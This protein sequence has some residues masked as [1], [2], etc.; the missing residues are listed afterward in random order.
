MSLIKSNSVQIGQSATATQ[1]FTLAV[2][3]SPDGTIKLA[4]GNAGATTQDVLSVDASGNVSFNGKNYLG[5]FSVAPTLNNQGLPLQSGNLYWNTVSNNLWAYNGTSWLITNFNETTP[6]FT[7]FATSG[8]ARSLEVRMR[9]DMSSVRDW[10]ATGNGTT[11]D[12]V[13]IQ[14]A[15]DFG[16]IKL[17][18]PVG[19]Y[20]VTAPLTVR[21]QKFI[22]GCGSSSSIVIDHSGTGI[23]L[24]PVGAGTSNV[25]LSGVELQDMTFTRPG[26]ITNPGDNIWIRQCNGFSARGVISRN[27]S[28]CFR[29]SGGQL[30]SLLQCRAFV[31]N[32][33]IVPQAD[34]GLVIF[35]KA[36]LSGGGYQPCYT[37]TI[38]DFVGSA[39][40]VL[41]Y[42]IKV[43]SIDGLNFSNAY[44]A[45]CSTSLIGVIREDINTAATAINLTNLYLDCTGGSSGTPYGI[46]CNH[47]LGAPEYS[48][49]GMNV[50]NCHIANNQDTGTFNSLV[51]FAKRAANVNFSNCYFANGGSPYGVQLY[52]DGIGAR[53]GKY[54]FTGCVFFNLS[55]AT[56]GGAI[57]S[58]DVDVLIVTGNTF[59]NT[60][61]AAYQV[62]CDGDVGSVT[63]IGN[64]A[65]NSAASIVT[66]SGTATVAGDVILLNAGT[67]SAP[68]QIRLALPTSSV[69]L[70]SGAM[71]NDGGTVKI[72]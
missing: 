71:W 52:D 7:Q 43:K 36:S 3:S 1:N 14:N 13:A 50:S 18:F 4:R 27:G 54:V 65:D 56:G 45:Y 24:E 41:Q 10:G 42:G 63:A 28:T 35:E 68:N 16:G 69:G 6:F 38:D 44:M 49:A 21:T 34:N 19:T 17:F 9:Q 31:G 32:T 39:S 30:N 5:G 61:T 46:F 59:A 20:R 22:H 11:D 37:T 12:T 23:V 33:S 60:S 57:Y 62:L 67:N 2:P 72:V 70:T 53:S 48:V 29:F 8:T 15:I 25:Y 64:I 58:K 51:Q 26:A 66:I 55:Q 40:G 47:A